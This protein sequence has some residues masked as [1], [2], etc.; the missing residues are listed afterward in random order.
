MA[1]S[2]CHSRSR[3]PSN[4]ALGTGIVDNG[5]GLG[6]P[7]GIGKLG[8]DAC[9]DGCRV[10]AIP[11]AGPFEG[12]LGL[13][14][15]DPDFVHLVLPARFE[16]HG[17]FQDHDGLAAPLG[18]ADVGPREVED[19]GPD[20]VR[21]AFELR[22]VAEHLATERPTV[23]LALAHD[24]VAERGD[25]LVEAWRARVVG[26]VPELVGIDHR[27]ATLAEVASGGGFPGCDAPREADDDQRAAFQCF[28]SRKTG[29]ISH[30][31]H[32]VPTPT[33]ACFFTK[34][35]GCWCLRLCSY[36]ATVAANGTPRLSAQR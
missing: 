33:L 35:I 26:A 27:G 6:H 12:D 4:A 31:R 25:H 29:D 7:L 36:T 14:R 16:Q 23:D 15:D 17:G 5:V 19:F 20:D 9:L 28:R 3:A 13:H 22:G 30:L 2:L 8:V 24:V 32:A 11:G 34:Y 18:R 10:H 1:L 21:Q